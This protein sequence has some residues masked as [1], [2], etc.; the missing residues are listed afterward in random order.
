MSDRE[1]WRRYGIEEADGGDTA[2]CGEYGS[3]SCLEEKQIGISL[4]DKRNWIYYVSILE[5]T[6]KKKHVKRK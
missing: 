1:P 3:S 4:E 5:K 6:W 2:S